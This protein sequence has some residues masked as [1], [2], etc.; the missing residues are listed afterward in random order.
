M[1]YMLQAVSNTLLLSIPQSVIYLAF[2]LLFWGLKLELYWRK[3]LLLSVVHSLYL[4]SLMLLTPLPV[5][6]MNSLISFAVLFF[7][8]FRTLSL[9]MKL[10]IQITFFLFIIITDTSA[11]LIGSSFLGPERMTEAALSDRLL[12]CWPFIAG[13]A[14]LC[15][16]FYRRSLSPGYRVRRFLTSKHHRPIFLFMVLIFIQTVVMMTYFFS[17]FFTRYDELI[18][19]L[20]YIGLAS[21]L[22][23]SFAAIRLLIRTREEAI[24]VTRSAYVNDVMQMLTSI[25]GQRHDFLNHM[26]VISSMLTMNKHEQ[27]KS[28]IEEISID[29]QAQHSRTGPLPG[30][31]VA[32]LIQS[33]AAAAA[34][35]QI[36]FS[37][38]IP[39]KLTMAHLR[40][41]DLIRILGNLTDNAFD[42]AATLPEDER[43]AHLALRQQEQRLEIVVSNSG[44]RLTEEDRQMM[45]TPGYTTKDKHHSG[46]G[47]AIVSDLVRRYDGTLSVES[48]PQGITIQASLHD[49]PP[50]P[51][52]QL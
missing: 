40:N 35:L 39:D 19:L 25:R 31:A 12:L 20:F 29:L 15:W 34:E 23:V 45:L 52:P 46:L 11:I 28:Y 33:K 27:L 21:T 30:A 24:R 22:F 48:G 43:Y 17:R 1:D 13:T 44:R 49:R 3:M 10:V 32:A 16:L 9:H 37:Y 42:E 7:L 38:E 2:S 47:L 4:N 14:A 41:T 50:Q 8:L 36:R 26:Q 5:H 6:F 18:K 51:E